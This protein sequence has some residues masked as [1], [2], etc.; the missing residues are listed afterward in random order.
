MS[1]AAAPKTITIAAIGNPN[2]GK[3]T[4][5]SALTGIH[6]RIGNFPGVTVEKKVGWFE[7]DGQRIQLVDLPGTYSLSPRTL[8]EMVSVEVLLGRQP[9][10]GSIDAVLCIADA[11]NLERHLYVVSQVLDLGLPVVL[12]LNMWDVARELGISIDTE[13]LSQRLGIPVV[14]C[15]AHRKQNISQVKQ[16]LAAVLQYP[17]RSRQRLFPEIFYA[18]ADSLQR[19]FPVTIQQAPAPG[20]LYE[21]L[22]LDPGGYIETWMTAE[23]AGR[24]LPAVQAARESLKSQG[25]RIPSIE[26][27]LRYAWARQVLTGLM[28]VPTERKEVFSDKIDRWLTHRFVGLGVFCVLMFIVFQAIYTGAE[29]LMGWIEEGQGWIGDHVSAWIPPGPLRSLVVD[30]MIAGVEVK[31]I[32]GR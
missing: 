26:A 4:L 16:A 23:H 19:D 11:S 18:A 32:C 2:S 7:V 3:S 25:C 1:V 10:V 28:H 9:E 5:F 29:P 20:Y 12:V 8:D 22:L 6:A 24:L 17:P 15:E 14:A 21:R 27:K 30:G 13:A 31:A